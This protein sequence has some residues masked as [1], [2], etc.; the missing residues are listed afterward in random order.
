MPI[1]GGVCVYDGEGIL[2]YVTRTVDR[3]G[4]AT[5]L[6]GRPVWMMSANERGVRKAFSECILTGHPVDT[7][8]VTVSPDG[9]PHWFKY[10]FHRQPKGSDNRIIS[11]WGDPLLGAKLSEQELTCLREYSEGLHQEE[12]AAKLFVDESTVKCALMRARAKLGARTSGQAIKIAT[13]AGL[14]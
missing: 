14:L 10:T 3:F 12:V 8:S 6:V 13:K 5:D 4:N 2:T 11:V 9:T 7:E 1:A